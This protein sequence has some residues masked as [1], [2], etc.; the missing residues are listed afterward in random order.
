MRALVTGSSGHLGEAL[1]RSLAARGHDVV[2]LDHRPSPSTTTV[3]SIV[4]PAL[5][6]GSMAGVDVV[7]H[8]ATLHKPHVSTHSRREFVETN[9][10]GTLTLLEAAVDAQVGAF[11]IT[12]TTS[13]FGRSL[14]PPPGGPAVWVTEET[15]PQP[16]NIY[17][18]TK[19]ASEQLAEEIHHDHGLPVVV[20]RTSRFFPEPDDR[21]E[22]RASFSDAN[23]KANE[24]LH[25]RVDLA[26]AAEAHILAA[27]RAQQVGF[28]RYVVSATTPFRH[29]HAVEL[30]RDAAAVVRELFPD[31]PQRYAEAGWSLPPVID[32]VYD[33][34]RAR[35]DLGWT[36]RYDFAR[37]LECLRTGEGW[38]SPLALEIGIKGYHDGAY[39]DGLYPT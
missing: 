37:V 21:P 32:R 4:E 8:T 27:E 29:E 16:R 22:V 14:T 17:G 20:L 15:S 24:L 31:Q 13:V 5:V 23:Q 12:S 34:A 38:R 19:L 28:G 35:A 2:G 1:V 11:V 6:R 30:S 9:I 7:L 25:R 3:G 39:P 33:N 26:D 36:P 10:T 18:A